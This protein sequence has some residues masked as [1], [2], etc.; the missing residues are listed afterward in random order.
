MPIRN[1]EPKI[2]L[3]INSN[4]NTY[5]NGFRIEIAFARP[6]PLPHPVSDADVRPVTFASPPSLIRFT[7]PVAF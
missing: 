4:S 5:E 2:H 6:L 1:F 7:L 3:N